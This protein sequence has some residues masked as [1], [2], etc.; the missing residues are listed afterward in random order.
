MLEGLYNRL[1]EKDRPLFERL[2]LWIEDR[3]PAHDEELEV[4]RR[5]AITRDSHL[6]QHQVRGRIDATDIK[7]E[8]TGFEVLAAV[9]ARIDSK[10]GVQ[11]V[12]S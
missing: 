9:F 8:L 10:I 4:L 7:H 12:F 1:A 2:R 5:Q 6:P 11:A 3:G